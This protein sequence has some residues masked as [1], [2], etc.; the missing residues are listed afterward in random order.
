[1]QSRSITLRLREQAEAEHFILTQASGRSG[2]FV[3]MFVEY[4]G[5]GDSTC[6]LFGVKLHNN[7]TSDAEG[8]HDCNPNAQALYA[9]I[10]IVSVCMMQHCITY[11]AWPKKSQTWI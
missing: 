4:W 6:V 8:K 1:M 5:G 3:G 11:T 10:H 7:K 9:L 2:L